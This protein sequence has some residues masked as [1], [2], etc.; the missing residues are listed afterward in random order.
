MSASSTFA[1]TLSLS[2]ATGT[3]NRGC[4]IPTTIQLD[5]QGADTDGTDAIIFYDTSRFNVTV[6]SIQN[7]TIY[8]DYPGNVVDSQA[9]KISISGI[10]SVSS[11]Y[12]GTGT[13]AT[14]NF[15]VLS[16][17]ATGATS[18]KFDF[19]P[20]D[21]A[22]TTDS[23]VV[24]RGT[25]ADLLNTVV[26]GNYTIGTGGNCAVV[27]GGVPGASGKPIGGPGTLGGLATPSAT[28][29]L[30]TLNPGGNSPGLTDSTVILA[31]VGGVLTIIGL[32]GLA[33]L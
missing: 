1:A 22:K 29:I 14:I 13:L 26:D 12:K 25:I 2:P 31:V 21:K 10:A 33:F 7:G 27:A 11:P 9:G 20:N 5:T 4:I 15:E 30:N 32:I 6:G 18:I 28:P 8:P 16:Q 23:N 17:A 3:L 19:D 24:E